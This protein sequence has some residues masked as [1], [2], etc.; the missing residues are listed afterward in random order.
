MLKIIKKNLYIFA[1][2]I[3]CASSTVIEYEQSQILNPEM[4]YQGDWQNAIQA[5]I[6]SA[7]ISGVPVEFTNMIDL[8]LDDLDAN[9]DLINIT[10]PDGV[11]VTG[12]GWNTGIKVIN[13]PPNNSTVFQVWGDDK[14][15][16][17]NFAILLADS[18]VNQLEHPT[19][20]I[21]MFGI[22]KR[23]DPN[24]AGLAG[25]I[26]LDRM[27]IS[28]FTNGVKA[29]HDAHAIY[30]ND[31]WISAREVGVGK[32]GNGGGR[33]HVTNSYLE[34]V[35]DID[36]NH[37]I[38]TTNSVNLL[39]DGCE[40]LQ[41]SS[42]YAIAVF[43]GTGVADY[44]IVRNTIIRS[45]DSIPQNQM[46]GI[47]TSQTGLMTIENVHIIGQNFVSGIAVGNKALI[48][49]CYIDIRDDGINDW[50]LQDTQ[51][52]ILGTTIKSNSFG[53]IL[54]NSQNTGTWKIKNCSVTSDSIMN[55]AIAITSGGVGRIEIEDTVLEKCVT[56]IYVEG[57]EVRVINTEVN[58]QIYTSLNDGKI[59]G[60][61]RKAT[62]R[63]TMFISGDSGGRIDLSINYNKYFVKSN[64][65]DLRYFNFMGVG[66]NLDGQLTIVPVD[67][68]K[69]LQDENNIIG[70][71]LIVK[72]KPVVY[73]FSR[74]EGKWMQGN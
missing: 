27:K 35:I 34:T 45:D 59:Y 54:S 49:N 48:K 30:V 31:S 62:K 65:Q 1:Y 61:L 58:P 26:Q 42:K 68:W 7:N 12:N 13:M 53:V 9:G 41:G 21:S 24:I 25:E 60:F 19:I 18:I 36:Q 51:A 29:E 17:D 16:F 70:D 28:G 47:V 40:I 8:T 69:I 39:V 63:D 64:G 72:N 3:N 44:Q 50:G 66:N 33:V 20:G 38:Y 67:S 4:F 22:L 56:A 2:L 74:D 5:A 10:V 6:D 32:W 71:S 15:R 43:G 52:E 73:H 55:T 23:D 57:G 37:A 46:S 14:A 11:T